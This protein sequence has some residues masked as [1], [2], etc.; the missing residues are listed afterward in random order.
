MLLFKMNDCVALPPEWA[1]TL[2]YIK[3]T[4]FASI[5]IIYQVGVAF[6]HGYKVAIYHSVACS[7]NGVNIGLLV[8]PLKKLRYH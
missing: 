3:I 8:S 6:I 2:L 4:L 5:V 7:C 1:S